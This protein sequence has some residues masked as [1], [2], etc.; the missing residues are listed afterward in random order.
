MYVC[1]QCHLGHSSI[2]RSLLIRLETRKLPA[3]I[4]YSA[5][6]LLAVI[7]VV[8]L[9]LSCDKFL[10]CSDPRRDQCQYLILGSLTFAL[11]GHIYIRITRAVFHSSGC[12]LPWLPGIC[13]RILLSIIGRLIWPG[14]C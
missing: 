9:L 8:V 1:A 14:R 7:V 3:S 12:V 5:F 6:L 2:A 13:S 11:L 10:D 4:I